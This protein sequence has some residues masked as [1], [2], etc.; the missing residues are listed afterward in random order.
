[1][2]KRLLCPQL[3]RK[4]NP[5]I[6]TET[7]AHHA[8]RVL[9]LRDGE[10]IEAMDGNGHKGFATLRIRG[11]QP[12]LEFI[13]SEQEAPSPQQVKKTSL[14]II[15]EMSVLKGDAMEW[16]V[17]KSVELGVQCLI[18]VLTDYTVV[19]MKSKSP[20]SFRERWQKIA[21]QALKQ[22][23]R[24]ERLEVRL[25]MSLENL[26]T[27]RIEKKNSTHSSFR[28]WADET[29]AGSCP[30][31]LNWLNNREP[32]PL[33]PE[34]RILVGPEGGWSSNERLLLTQESQISP[35]YR[36]DLGPQI[37]RAETAALFAIS[38]VSAQLRL[39]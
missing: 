4:G 32:S 29:S 22:C 18:P 14:P 19:Q 25:P 20:D 9:R 26:L 21:D 5:S 31:I 15:L 13:E 11:G 10:I 8:I 23:G 36:V 34:I 7:E 28:L 1:M 30:F 12:R 35:I 2:K 16:V 24:L 39:S 17:E 38:V 37:L 6:L 33:P 27:E 3:P